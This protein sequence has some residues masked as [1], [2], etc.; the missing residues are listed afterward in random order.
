[1]LFLESEDQGGTSPEIRSD[2]SH[3]EKH[4]M[5]AVDDMMPTLGW[6]WMVLVRPPKLD[7]T[8]GKRRAGWGLSRETSGSQAV[9][10]HAPPAARVRISTQEVHAEHNLPRSYLLYFILLISSDILCNNF[11]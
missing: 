8:I 1:M 3:G 4:C 5:Y 11:I 10:G 7:Q 2:P 9:S 6:V